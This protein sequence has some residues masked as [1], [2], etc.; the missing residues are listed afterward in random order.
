MLY[1]CFSQEILEKSAETRILGGCCFKL[2][3]PFLTIH[4]YSFAFPNPP[5]TPSLHVTNDR[6]GVVWCSRVFVYAYSV[7]YTTL[8]NIFHLSSF[9]FIW[10]TT[11]GTTRPKPGVK[12]NVYHHKQV[13][14]PGTQQHTR[15]PFVQP[16]P[17]GHGAAHGC[18]PC[19]FPMVL[20]LVSSI[21]G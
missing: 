17:T 7:H 20:S 2:Q 11:S 13:H 14:P 1:K 9:W 8:S 18:F 16:R 19:L 5:T 10:H 15:R 21:Q 3:C 12:S 4:L 6:Q